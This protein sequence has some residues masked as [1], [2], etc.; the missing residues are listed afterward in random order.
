MIYDAHLEAAFD[1]GFATIGSSYLNF[2]YT[3]ADSTELEA[4]FCI[5]P[6]LHNL[7]IT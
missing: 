6:S 2:R 4:T 3:F 5:D 7:F 1:H